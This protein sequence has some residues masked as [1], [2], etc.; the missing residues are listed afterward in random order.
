MGSRILRHLCFT[1]KSAVYSSTGEPGLRIVLSNIGTFG[2]INPL[3][4]VALE[5]KR[6]GHVPVMALPDVY[7]SKIE[8]L[9]LEFHSLRPDIDP[10]NTK[11]VEMIYDVKK[12]TETGLRE[13]LFPVLRQTYD[14]LLDAA[15]KPD[16]RRSA[17]A[18]RAELCR[19]DRGRSDGHS[20]G[21]LCAGAVLVFLGVRSARAAAVSQA[22]ARRQG[23]GHGPCHAAVGA[24]CHAQVA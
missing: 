20:L 14:D 5:L 7:R 15:T 3:I 4:A 17:A 2:D 11:L 6:R 12:G 24:L 21:E 18:G 16:A 1:L 13:F 9:G 19:A 10:G 8:P 22:G 23:S